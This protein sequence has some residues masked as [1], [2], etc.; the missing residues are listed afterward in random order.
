MKKVFNVSKKGLTVLVSAI[1]LMVCMTISAMP[2]SAASGGGRHTGAQPG[3][4][5][6]SYY[7][8]STSGIIY[9]KDNFSFNVNNDGSITLYSVY[10]DS[11]GYPAKGWYVSYH[12]GSYINVDTC[13]GSNP[14]ISIWKWSFPTVKTVT[15]HY[16]IYNSG[17]VILNYKS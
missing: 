13:W 10:Q 14:S 15:C 7:P 16:T 1:M 9:A 4:Y 17:Q 2:A 11:C 12:G 8:V 3:Y 5:S 6:R